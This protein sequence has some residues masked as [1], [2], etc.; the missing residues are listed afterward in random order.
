MRVFAFDVS[1]S[2]ACL[3]DQM[4]VDARRISDDSKD[5]A[6]VFS[7]AGVSK[8]QLLS[9][10]EFRGESSG[11]DGILEILKWMETRHLQPTDELIIYHD[12]YWPYQR[13]EY[14][15]YQCWF[16]VKL[17]LFKDHSIDA[18]DSLRAL[19][20]DTTILPF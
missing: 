9:S 18:E 7:S 2:S 17:R 4:V 15:M 10:A 20:I 11:G 16:T 1:G 5:M 13:L 14:V 6:V 12:G 8:A 3:L 19:E